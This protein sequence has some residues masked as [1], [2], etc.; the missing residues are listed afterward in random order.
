MKGCTRRILLSVLLVAAAALGTGCSEGDDDDEE[1]PTVNEGGTEAMLDPDGLLASL[2]FV[3]SEDDARY[4]CLLDRLDAQAGAAGFE[5]F[6]PV[7]DRGDVLKSWCAAS[8]EDG[9]ACMRGLV[10]G[11]RDRGNRGTAVW[12]YRERTQATVEEYGYRVGHNPAANAASV[13]ALDFERTRGSADGFVARYVPFDGDERD[14]ERDILVGERGTYRIEGRGVDDV[15]ATLRPESSP[16]LLL[17]TLVES[18]A[19]FGQT[20]GERSDA[21]LAEYDRELS[22]REGLDEATRLSVLARARE[23]IGIDRTAVDE[24]AEAMHA[25]LRDALIG[26][27]CG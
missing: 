6:R 27:D 7:D 11:L 24:N 5:A 18:P 19:R 8:G 16:A 22:A 2:A 12:A 21:L 25:L 13:W 9:N 10:L 20:L 17:A 23:E 1:V 4:R 26:E 14:Y 15:V 3:T